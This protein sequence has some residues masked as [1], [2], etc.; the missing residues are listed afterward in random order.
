MHTL[1]AHRAV[2]VS[3]RWFPK[4]S[5]VLSWLHPLF[6]MTVVGCCSRVC[7]QKKTTNKKRVFFGKWL[8]LGRSDGYLIS[9]LFFF[10]NRLRTHCNYVL[11]HGVGGASLIC[12]RSNELGGSYIHLPL[13][14]R[15]VLVSSND[16]HFIVSPKT[17]VA[18]LAQCRK[19]KDQQTAFV[20]RG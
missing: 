12:P 13:A 8:W 16:Q 11:D 10:A 1:P 19:Q 14:L 2:S 9:K 6:L 17:S 3:P 15:S 18:I 7:R 5:V 4:L 20:S